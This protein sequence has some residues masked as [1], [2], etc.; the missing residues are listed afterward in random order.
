MN[1]SPKFK[2]W[3]AKKTVGQRLLLVLML[4][5]LLS[6]PSLWIPYYNVDETTNALFGRFIAQGNLDLK[7][8]L[9]NTYIFTHYLYG[10]VYGLFGQNSLVAMHA[11]HAIWKSLT[12]LAMYVAG[13]RIM[14]SKAGLWSALLSSAL[15]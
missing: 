13:N 11:I 1:Q 7:Y 15:L 12:I 3:L 10:G 2:D 8:F 6:V 14:G 9:G 5:L 4:N